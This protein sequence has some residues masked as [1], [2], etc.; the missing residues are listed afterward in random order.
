M[1]TILLLILTVEKTVI[2]LY[3]EGFDWFPF[4]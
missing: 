4:L 2:I 1:D 3:H